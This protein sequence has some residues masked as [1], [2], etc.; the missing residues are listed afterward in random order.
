MSAQADSEAAALASTPE[1]RES[2]KAAAFAT[3]LGDKKKAAAKA[4]AK[5]GSAASKASSA[6]TSDLAARV[7]DDTVPPPARCVRVS[8]SNPAILLQ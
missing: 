7:H 4:N 1:S 5:K 6:K 3:K 8:S 2:S